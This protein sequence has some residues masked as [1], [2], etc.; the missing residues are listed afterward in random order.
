MK[1]LLFLFLWGLPLF[2]WAQETL[3]GTIIDAQSKE[4]LAFA[5]VVVTPTNGTISNESGEFKF[6]NFTE[7]IEIITVSYVGYQTEEVPF[8]PGKL[9]YL[10][11]L[12]KVSIPLREVVV[13]AVDEYAYTLFMQAIKNSRKH[14][15]KERKAKV[16]RRTYSTRDQQYPT[17]YLEAFYNA[18][19]YKGSIDRLHLKNGRVGI[20]KDNYVLSLDVGNVLQSWQLYG[21][22]HEYLPASPFSCKTK[23]QLKEDYYV[24]LTEQLEVENDQIFEISFEANKAGTAFGGK[25]YIRA[26]NQVVERVSLVLDSVQNIAFQTVLDTA[27]TR[28][29][30]MSAALEIGFGY[31]KKGVVMEYLHLV[32]DFDIGSLMRHYHLH[33]NSKFFFFD[34]DNLFRLP[35]FSL[36]NHYNDYEKIIGIPY[37][38]AFWNRTRPLEETASERDFRQQLEE[39][40]LFDNASDD[41]WNIVVLQKRFVPWKPDFQAD[42]NLISKYRIL[43]ENSE[44]GIVYEKTNGRQL[45]EDNLFAHTFLFLDYDCF[46]D[47]VIFQAEA[48]VDY[49]YSY[50]YLRDGLTWQYFNH[51]LHLTKE[52]AQKLE[53]ELTE[54]YV[55]KCPERVDIEFEL[56]AAERQLDKS[57]AAYFQKI[58][59]NRSKERLEKLK[60]ETREK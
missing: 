1:T 34:Y 44:K 30:N 8:I 57:A 26:S 45:P 7:K 40:N 56:K 29:E 16:F 20:P 9:D 36:S 60:G 2:V 41:N 58:Q 48:M 13:D 14:S 59:M 15:W 52:H 43:P 51:F 55:Q 32:L 3:S 49:L 38:E 37:N 35:F 42:T 5:T 19:L 28:I 33:S 23:K 24:R 4:P 21:D 17:E 18:N 50:S 31:R 11:E 54:K 12:K 47:T 27:N 53:T 46:S 10:I 39:N 25:A 22:R 6:Q